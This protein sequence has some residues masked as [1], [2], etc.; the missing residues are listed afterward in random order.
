V[1]A[2]EAV[3]LATLCKTA[4][5][6]LAATMPD[7]NPSEPFVPEQILALPLHAVRVDESLLHLPRRKSRR[8]PLAAAI[9][10]LMFPSHDGS[11]SPLIKYDADRVKI[12]A[13]VTL[14]KNYDV[15]VA[16]ERGGHSRFGVN[17]GS[18]PGV[19]AQPWS[20]RILQQGPWDPTKAPVS[21][22][23]PKCRHH[24][25][26]VADGKDLEPL[27]SHLRNRGTSQKTPVCLGAELGG[28]HGEP[29]YGTKGLEFKRGVVYEDRRMDLHGANL[30]P[31]HVEE[32]MTNLRTNTFVKHFLLGHN[33]IGPLGTK[34]ISTF[35]GEFPDRIETWYLAGNAMDAP[36]FRLLVDAM[37]KSRAVTSIWLKNNPLGP[38]AVG[39]I[40]RLVTQTEELRTLDLDQTELGDAGVSHLFTHLADHIEST[41]QK[42]KLEI[43]HLNGNGISTAGAAS[44]ARFLAAQSKLSS[45]TRVH[46]L[47]L[48]LNP[49]G[50]DGVSALAKAGISQ[51]PHLQRLFLQ[52]VGLGSEGT[53]HLCTALNDHKG[54]RVLDLSQCLATP[55]L[56]Q[57]FNY[58]DDDALTSLTN[59]LS[60]TAR[61]EYLSLGHCGLHPPALRA[62]A[63]TVRR[64][65]SLVF[66]QALCLHPD[67]S[68]K[69]RPLIPSQGNVFDDATTGAALTREPAEVEKAVSRKMEMNVRA[70]YGDGVTYQRFRDE[71]KRWLVCDRQNAR[72]VDSVYRGREV[73]L[74]RRRVLMMVKG[75]LPE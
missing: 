1:D 49:L 9:A 60:S 59:L 65:S 17:G 46:T 2:K 12:R 32:L 11:L 50:N 30:G 28:G 40:L 51:A 62:L 23:G 31:T 74:S 8:M 45:T 13:W 42:L 72:R 41:G 39:D 56:G 5:N 10:N 71:E 47:H 73:E 63:D 70:R 55:E 33:N 26:E 20:A 6:L 29:F 14:Q 52:S 21:L 3:R 48:S 67:P 22:D 34:A 27:F 66:Y 19:H 36:S 18:A 43:L 37:V 7:F 68:V 25:G 69:L 44:L 35:L 24:P 61:L 58:I 53:M 38:K 64:S 16:T 54:I 57:P 4:L 75:H 15:L